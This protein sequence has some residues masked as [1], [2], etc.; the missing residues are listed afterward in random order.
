M[1]SAVGVPIRPEED[2]NAIPKPNKG[3]G[4]PKIFRKLVPKL[5]DWKVS[6]FGVLRTVGR[7]FSKKMIK[8]YMNRRL[9]ML[10]E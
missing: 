4:P 6:P 1:L 2:P 5:W 8:G 7:G 3:R 9:N 10:G